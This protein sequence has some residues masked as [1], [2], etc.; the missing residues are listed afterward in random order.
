[1]LAAL[2]TAAAWTLLA[3]PALGGQTSY[4]VTHGESMLPAFHTGDFALVREQPRYQ[5]GDVIAYRS[6]TLHVVV[7]HRIIGTESDGLR[8]RGDHNNW[9]DPDLITPDEVIGRL[10]LHIPTIGSALTTLRTAAPAVLIAVATTATTALTAHGARRR[11]SH[12]KATPMHRNGSHPP[13][14]SLRFIGAVAVIL[15]CALL[16][17][18]FRGATSEG[19]AVIGSVVHRI[20]VSYQAPAD[21]E[22][23]Q[24]G[25]LTTGDPVFTTLT[26]R[27]DVRVGYRVTGDVPEQAPGRLDLAARLSS[28]NGWQRLIPL[29]STAVVS[30]GVTEVTGTLDLAQLQAVV[31]RVQRRTGSSG[32]GQQLDLV[33]TVTGRSATATGAVPQLPS[34]SFRF[35][36]GQLVLDDGHHSRGAPVTRTATETV[37]AAASG[38]ARVDFAGLSVAAWQ[39]RAAGAVAVVLGALVGGVGLVGC[40]RDPLAGLT[41]PVITVTDHQQVAT[42]VETSSLNGLLDLAHRYDWPVLHLPAPDESIY[43]ERV[44]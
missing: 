29:G 26:P 17:L 24:G 20:D 4:V 40:R 44:C 21:A 9:T 5:V 31:D 1:M 43:L 23:Y 11:R 36:D 19:P 33:S 15:G 35:G 30:N 6:S 37:T 13:A 2:L 38:G 10:W 8:T 41:K 32:V 42:A 39:V 18:S 16:L 7:L 22:V 34:V 27:V 12:R 25:E 3:P 28:P 14:S